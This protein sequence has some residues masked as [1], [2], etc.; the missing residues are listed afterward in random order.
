MSR[1]IRRSF[2]RLA[3]VSLL[4]IALLAA[5]VTL[6]PGVATQAATDSPRAATNLYLPVVYGGGVSADWQPKAG[7]WQSASKADQFYVSPSQTEV[8]AFSTMVSVGGCG[9]YK[10]TRLLGQ[11]IVN[12]AFSFTGSFYASGTFTS[13]TTASGTLGLSNFKID[14]C[15]IVSGGPWSYDATWQNATQ[16]GEAGELALKVHRLGGASAKVGQHQADLIR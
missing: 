13:E 2:A 16:P 9:T 14:G 8:R 3:L 15:G 1:P 4:A 7:L 10:I 11:S 12:R 5:V 6:L